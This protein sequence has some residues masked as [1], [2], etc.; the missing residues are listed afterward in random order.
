[1][2]I[3]ASVG[4]FLCKKTNGIFDCFFCKKQLFSKYKYVENFSIM[5]ST[6]LLF[7][8]FSNR[9]IFYFEL[10]CSNVGFDNIKI[11]F[12]SIFCRFMHLFQWLLYICSSSYCIKKN[13]EDCHFYFIPN[14]YFQN[15]NPWIILHYCFKTIATILFFWKK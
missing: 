10:H 8:N 11:R 6:L 15:M 5:L 7:C 2:T 12:C 1:M 9:Y 14:N 3:C 4:Y 13:Y